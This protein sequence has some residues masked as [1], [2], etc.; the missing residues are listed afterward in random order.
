[1]TEI[2]RRTFLTGAAAVSVGGPAALAPCADASAPLFPSAFTSW[3]TFREVIMH[4]SMMDALR[5]TPKQRW[6]LRY[7]EERMAR[8]GQKDPVIESRVGTWQGV[9]FIEEG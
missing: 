5:L 3:P 4:P 2:D 9:R 6:K 1:M 7:R 8:K